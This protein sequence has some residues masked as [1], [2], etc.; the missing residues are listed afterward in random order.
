MVAVGSFSW[1]ATAAFLAVMLTVVRRALTRLGRRIER[2]GFIDP[3]VLSILFVMCFVAS[4]VADRIGLTVIPGAFVAGAVLP[5]RA[6]VAVELPAKL[7]DITLVVLLPVFLA[8]S[9]LNT[10]F[11]TVGIAV[12]PLIGLFLLTGIVA[13]WGGV[14]CLRGW[15]G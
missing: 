10:D 8:Y 9:G 4:L 3:T 15:E 12:L 6:I 7:R 11:T 5:A 2:Q 1:A 14:A 13:K